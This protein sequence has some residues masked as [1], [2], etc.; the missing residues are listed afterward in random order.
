[1]YHLFRL[2]MFLAGSMECKW[3]ID[4]HGSLNWQ[5]ICTRHCVS[6]VSVLR[7]RAKNLAEDWRDDTEEQIGW[8][9][10]TF[11]TKAQ[12]KT[13]VAAKQF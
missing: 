5:G 3:V 9:F 11:F 4:M 6:E 2:E 7:E 12:S 13:P 1:M 10:F 8:T